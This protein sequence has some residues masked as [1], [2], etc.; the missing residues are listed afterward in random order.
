MLIALFALSQ[1]V[2]T[3][4]SN[5]ETPWPDTHSLKTFGTMGKELKVLKKDAE[6]ELFSYQGAGCIT[7]M[8]FGGSFKD[9]E[10]TDIRIY[11]DGEEQ[12][13]ID[14]ELFL[15]HGIGFGDNHA[16]WGTQRMGN[17][18]GNSGIY[19]TYKRVYQ[20]LFVPFLFNMLRRRCKQKTPKQ[21]A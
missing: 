17:I 6:T 9:V 12:A 10:Y 5:Q 19:N 20:H 13:A 16:P 3:A 8:W 11:V 14:M 15:G 21:S 18:G 7:H 1:S 4:Q 2:A